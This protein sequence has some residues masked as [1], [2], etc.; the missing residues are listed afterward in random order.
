MPAKTTTIDGTYYLLG[1]HPTCGEEVHRYSQNDMEELFSE[2][3]RLAL[4]SGLSV[5]TRHNGMVWNN[6][7]LAA[8]HA[9]SRHNPV[10]R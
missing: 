6:M 5:R 4:D 9:P 8:R 7:L 10:V 3:E 1:I 2:A